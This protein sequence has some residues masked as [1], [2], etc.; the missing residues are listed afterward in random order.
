MYKFTK[1]ILPLTMY[2][3]KRHFFNDY[4]Y[5]EFNSDSCVRVLYTQK[6][7]FAIKTSLL[8]RLQEQTLPDEAAI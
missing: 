2:Y 3:Q 7:K 5:S 6:D 1:G 4:Y 8:R